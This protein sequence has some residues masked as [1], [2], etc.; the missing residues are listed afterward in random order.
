MH[1]PPTVDVRRISNCTRCQVTTPQ[2]SSRTEPKVL[3]WL[4][5]EHSNLVAAV[6][7]VNAIGHTD[8][9][10][11]LPLF[12]SGY[13]HYRRYLGDSLAVTATAQ[14][15]AAE[16]GDRSGEA[17]AWNSFGVALRAARRFDESIDA[18][19][20]AERCSRRLI[21]TNSAFAIGAPTSDVP[22]GDNDARRRYD[23]CLGKHLPR[24]AL[25][26]AESIAPLPTEQNA[27]RRFLR[28]ASSFFGS[29]QLLKSHLW[30]Q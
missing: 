25:S 4:D 20:Q 18:P 13:L 7:A 19:A 24:I 9:A 26:S 2:Q 17:R 3:T 5:T 14:R 27:A 23:L 22:S 11:H 29:G 30:P 28:A 1:I 6:H 21:P 12:L 15:T 8:T 16:I 10:I